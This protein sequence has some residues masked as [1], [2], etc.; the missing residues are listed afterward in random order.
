MVDFEKL[1]RREQLK[2]W[3]T[4]YFAGS[5]EDILARTKKIDCSDVYKKQTT[6]EESE[7]YVFDGNG[8]REY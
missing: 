1:K 7:K 3:L 2:E 5:H 4:N 8:Y 6:T